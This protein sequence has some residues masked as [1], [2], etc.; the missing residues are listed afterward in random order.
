MVEKEIRFKINDDIKRSV[1]QSSELLQEKSLC[2]D[3]CMG[4]YGF[5]SLDKL[6]YIIRLRNQNGKTVMESKKRINENEWHEY[7][8]E[9]N[10]MKEG[11]NFLSNTGLTPY[12]YINRKREVR[13]IK[14]AKIFLDEID[15]LGDYIEFELEAGFKFS[16]LKQYIEENKISGKPQK[17][18]GDIFKEKLEEKEFKEEFEKR[19]NEFLNI[20]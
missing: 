5:D 4:K 19:I 16:D 8:I 2:I 13:K 20:K 14:Q 1:I 11:Y 15:L 7:K 12:L 3:L 17:L 6:G 9:L 10:D 18:Y